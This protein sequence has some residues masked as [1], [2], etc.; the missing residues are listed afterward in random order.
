ME[1]KATVYIAII[2]LRKIEDDGILR[3]AKC[4]DFR[5]KVKYDAGGEFLVWGQI[6]VRIKRNWC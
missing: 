1:K 6:K 5:P 4:L 3:K 2:D